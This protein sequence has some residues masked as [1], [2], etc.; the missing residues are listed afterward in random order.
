MDQTER[1]KHLRKRLLVLMA[2]LALSYTLTFGVTIYLFIDADVFASDWGWP[3]IMGMV[4]LAFYH[5]RGQFR[6]FD[7][8]IRSAENTEDE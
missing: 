1:V 4:I 8:I 7:A 2:G 3:I 5:L 6:R